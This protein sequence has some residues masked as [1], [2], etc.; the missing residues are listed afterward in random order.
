MSYLAAMV[1]IKS[2][3]IGAT[4]E[5]VSALPASEIGMFKCT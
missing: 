1:I 4:E 2:Y 3:Y 5:K